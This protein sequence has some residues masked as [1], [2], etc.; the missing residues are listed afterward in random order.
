MSDVSEQ[1]ESLGDYRVP[2]EREAVIKAHVATLSETAR[3]VSD[4]LAFAADISDIAG[5]LEENAD[6]IGNER[7]GDAS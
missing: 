3:R 6:E 5:V 1:P 2:D 4:E 7:P